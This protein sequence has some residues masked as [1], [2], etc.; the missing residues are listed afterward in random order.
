[1]SYFDDL[2]NH[3]LLELADTIEANGKFSVA[4]FEA[5]MNSQVGSVDGGPGGLLAAI[6]SLQNTL[7]N[8]HH[9]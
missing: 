8:N 4:Q 6:A 2:P 5:F 3:L 9:H 1:M 7:H